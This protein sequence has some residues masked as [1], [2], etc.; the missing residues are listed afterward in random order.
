MTNQI[1][2]IFSSVGNFIVAIGVLLFMI[3]V[4]EFGHYIAGK[5]LGFKINEFAIGF[6]PAIFK[7]KMKSGEDFSVRC[8][9]LGGYCAFEG[10]D[11]DSNSPDSFE[12]KSPWKRIIVLVA[13]ATANIIATLLI[14]V[15]VFLFA[16]QYFI[17]VATVLPSPPSETYNRE[18]VFQ[19][20]DYI[21]EIDGK[22]VY[23]TSVL[24]SQIASAKEDGEDVINVTIVR[25]GKEMT[26]PVE[27]RTYEYTYEEDGVSKT[28]VSE[29]VGILSSSGAV[30]FGF[31]RTI[32]NSFGY[33]ISAAG[34]IYTFL[35]QLFTGS[36]G[37]DSVGGP[38]T[39]I[40]M[41]A[42]IA[43]MGWR[44]LLEFVALIGINLA[45]FN[46]LPIPA[47]DGSKIVFTAIEW[48]RGKPINRNTENMI[49][50]IG[51]VAIF[52]F[53]IFVDL[54]KIF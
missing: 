46:L 7:R 52:A 35:G 10:E 22:T 5:K 30:K 47:L 44:V 53:A 17:Q 24:T 27:I 2:S 9:P 12:K 26:I 20:G 28:V 18:Y 48:V 16:G 3:T 42:T 45:V 51:F 36:V 11:T 31:F 4:H 29:G 6:G 34:T 19:T 38:V 49:H 39:T 50:F 1:L 21:I 14:I 15:C 8:I 43:S 37:L 32:G 40:T 41:T 25:D 13:G 54:I 23:S 33:C